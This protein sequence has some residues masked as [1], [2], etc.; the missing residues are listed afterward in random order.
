VLQPLS[1]SAPST[2]AQPVFWNDEATKLL[3]AENPCF[4]FSMD[5]KKY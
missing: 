2:P 3:I 5:K 1:E 4:T